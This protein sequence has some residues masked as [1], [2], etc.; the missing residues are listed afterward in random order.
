MQNITGII[1]SSGKFVVKYNCSAYGNVSV[2]QDTNDLA[3]I[4]PFLYKGYYFDKESGMFYC[5]T[6]YYVPEWCRWLNEDSA[7]FIDVN[8]INGLNV[9]S[10]CENNPVLLTDRFGTSPRWINI[11]AWIGVGLVAAAAIVLTA[12][13]AGV[14]VGGVVGAVIHGAAVGTLIGASV[15]AGVG[16]VGGMVYDAV[17]GNEFGTSVLDGVKIGFGVGAITGMLIGGTVGGV[18]YTPSG[19][20]RFA[21]NKAVN[22]TLA[23][24]NKMNHIMQVKHGLP[25]S[26][27]AVG[28]LMKRTLIKG[29]IIPYKSVSSAVLAATHSQ[30]TFTLINGAIMISDMWIF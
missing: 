7:S 29:T 27:S 18:N 28:K 13:A 9:F 5:H 21:I 6:R 4:N 16:A 1:D 25:N 22:R 20:N 12:G 23:D 30:V 19:L 3:S 10:Y 2:L 8:Y 17:Q 24:P 26:P 14:A 11:L 15:G